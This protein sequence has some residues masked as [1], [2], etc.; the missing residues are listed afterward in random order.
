MPFSILLD[1]Y[2]SFLTAKLLII[3]GDP[4]VKT[5]HALES[6]FINSGGNP[7][8]LMQDSVK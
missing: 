8:E 2:E 7:F 4:D 5:S 1:F 6:V 3:L